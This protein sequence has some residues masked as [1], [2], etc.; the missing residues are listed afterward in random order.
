MMNQRTLQRTASSKVRIAI[1]SLTL[2]L[3]SLPLGPK[4]MT[5]P[6]PGP[7]PTEACIAQ[8][9]IKIE[10]VLYQDTLNGKDVVHVEWSNHATSP[11]V[12]FGGGFDVPGSSNITAFGNE[13]TVKIR[14]RLG[15]EDSATAKGTSITD[16]NDTVSNN[17]AIPR[18]TLETD[19]VSYE[20]KVRTTAGMAMSRTARLTGSGAPLFSAATQ[21]FSNHSTVPNEISSCGPN[22][23]VSALDFIPGAGPKP[24]RVTISWTAGLPPAASCFDGP[25]I[26]IIV[27]LTRPN[28]VVDLGQANVDAGGTT[29]T[30]TLPGTPGKVAS[31]EILVTASTGSVIER[32][33]TST[34]NF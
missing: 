30:I 23:Q 1:L 14:R 17:V 7:T 20:V 26:S 6:I 29:A 32:V 16:G 31:F 27:R 18:D 15:N 3:L 33:S 4:A 34:G 9:F 8:A 5:K 2:I 13:V 22:L 11:C 10:K 21:T 12:R 19:P 24:D 28:G 25:K